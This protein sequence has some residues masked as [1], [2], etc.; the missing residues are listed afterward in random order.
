MVDVVSA[1]VRSRMMSG[2]RGKDT[3]PE[4]TL[5]SGLHRAGFRFRLHDRTLPGNPDMVFPRWHAVVF[6]HGCFWHGHHCH[7]FKWPKSR[8]EFWRTK[9]V[10]NRDVDASSAAALRKRGWR[11]GVVWECALKGR[12]RLP[13][14]EVVAACA[15]WL[16]SDAPSLEIRGHK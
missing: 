8:E 16:R 2:I 6:A 15:A 3:K 14:G 4:M 13:P 5:R 7:L 9:I 1:E 11:R 10:R 12:T